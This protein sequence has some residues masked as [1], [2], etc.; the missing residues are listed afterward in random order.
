MLAGVV[1][2]EG[3]TAV[4]D[5]LYITREGSARDIS[6]FVQVVCMLRS[7]LKSLKAAVLWA[8]DGIHCAL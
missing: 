3:S 8:N 1:D 7:D 4:R 5:Y 2:G 6:D